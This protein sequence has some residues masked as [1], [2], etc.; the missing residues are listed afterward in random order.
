MK[1]YDRLHHLVIKTG[2]RKINLS[3]SR[4]SLKDVALKLNLDAK[5]DVEFII[6]KVILLNFI[7]YLNYLSIKCIRDG[8]INAKIDHENQHLIMKVTIFFYFF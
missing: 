5:S 6:A 7:I 2:L 4:I 8:V 1:N 3:Y